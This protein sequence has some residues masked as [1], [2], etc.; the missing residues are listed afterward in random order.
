M[1]NFIFIS[2]NFPTNYWQF[3]R[4]LK[5]NGMNVLGIGDQP[6]D[7]LKPELKDSLNEYYKVGSLENYDEVYRAVAFFAFKYGRIDWLESN[8]EYWLERDAALRTDFNI[9]SGF[10]TEDMPRIKYKSKMKEY[11]QKAGIATA[12]YHMVDDYEG[13]RK[14]IDEVGYPV[15]VKPDNG[16]GASDTHKLS[17]DEDL[18]K[19]L[20]QKTA[21]HPD[22]E[23]IMEEFVRAEV[24]S[25][26]AIIDANGNP[27]FEAGNV[28]PMSI[29]DIVN[30][31]DNSIYYIIKDLPEDT[32]AAGRA[33]V[34]SFGVKSRFVHFEFFRMTEDQASM[35][36]KGQIVALEV[37][38]RPCGG[39]T[40]DMIDFARSTNVYKIWADMIAFGG[41]DMPVGEHYYCAFAGRRDGKHFVYSHEQIMQKYQK[42]MK[43][44]DR[45]P[46]ALSGAMGNQMYVANFSTREEMEQF[47]SDVLAVTDPINA[48]VQK[49]LTEVLA[50]GEPDA[51]STKAVT[52][53]PDLTPAI[54]PTT[55]VAETKTKAV[56]EV[57]TRA[58]TETP[59]KAVATQPTK[60][61]TKTPTKAVTK[62][63]TKAVTKTSRKGKK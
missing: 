49:E 14:F 34:K 51:A 58:V 33:V 55:A 35:G 40:P 2:P 39:F 42:N 23:Y 6:Y 54:K 25:Y 45:I 48:K 18:K 10:Q 19:F 53:K 17:S 41:T 30:D 26:D 1:Q 31:N 43:M 60:A 20:V 59:T 13:C 29:M 8:N 38:M 24:N 27:I 32:R 44:V 3:C 37:N 46:D 22:V 28:S 50:L 7:E 21:H 16:V 15:V 63:P 61:V 5:N 62:T 47:Y 56:A 52:P 12:R 36:K 57:P 4:E 11:Y 9:K